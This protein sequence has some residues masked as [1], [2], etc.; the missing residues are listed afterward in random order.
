M[1]K[2]LVINGANFNIN[3]LTTIE[4]AEEIP[5]TSLSLSTSSVTITSYSTI[6]VTATKTPNNTTDELLWTSSNTSVATV[7]DGVINPVGVGTCTITAICGE[8]TATVSVTVAFAYLGN[9]SFAL[10]GYNANNGILGYTYPSY[11]YILASGKGEQKTDKAL[12]RSSSEISGGVYG[13]KL[14]NGT[15]KVRL[16]ITD[17]SNIKSNQWSGGFQWLHDV[18]L[19][20]SHPTQITRISGQFFNLKTEENLLFTPPEGADSFVFNL[21]L[22]SSASTED[23]PETIID[24]IGFGIEFLNE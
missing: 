3:K 4:F 1:A 12:A 19:D 13:I 7:D 22:A 16:T 18:A 14:P 8:Q 5:C 2:T 10:L 20:Q 9:Y 21:Q 6:T 24:N 15:T 17:R 23:D 11:D